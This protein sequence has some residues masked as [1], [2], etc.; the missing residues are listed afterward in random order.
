MGSTRGFDRYAEQQDVRVRRPE[1]SG[2]GSDGIASHLGPGTGGEAASGGAAN[3][4][5]G[6]S[7]LNPAAFQKFFCPQ[8]GHG[9]ECFAVKVGSMAYHMEAMCPHCYGRV[10]GV[11]ELVVG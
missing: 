2:E 7:G 3:A 6:G 9:I 8:C 10:Q 1:V 11:V 5:H 4:H